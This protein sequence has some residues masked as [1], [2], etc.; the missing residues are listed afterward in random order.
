[1]LGD[2]ARWPQNRRASLEGGTQALTIG[3]KSRAK[4]KSR[5]QR[6]TPGISMSACGPA[7]PSLAHEL[8]TAAH[9]QHQDGPFE[10]EGAGHQLP[11]PPAED[12][13]TQ[14]QP[15]RADGMLEGIAI[16]GLSDSTGALNATRSR[17]VQLESCAMHYGT[18]AGLHGDRPTRTAERIPH[19]RDVQ[20]V[21][22]SDMEMLQDVMGKDRHLK[23]YA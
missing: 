8:D 5:I 18:Q 13:T 6:G 17:V 2:S 10:T 7:Q 20:C 19:E 15:A 3:H 21:T 16:R 4:D 14:Q 23:K 12:N 9:S 11:V 22:V 1:M